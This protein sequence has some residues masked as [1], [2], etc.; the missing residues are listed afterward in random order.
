[1]HNHEVG[2][3]MSAKVHNDMVTVSEYEILNT[4]EAIEMEEEEGRSMVEMLGVLAIMGVLS[5][6]AIAG[7]KYAITKHRANTLIYESNKCAVVLAGQIL[8][9]TVPSMDECTLHNLGYGSFVNHIYGPNGTGDWTHESPQFSIEIENVNQKVCD[10]MLEMAGG[11]ISA[12]SPETCAATNTIML[13]YNN[14]LSET[15]PTGYVKEGEK[16]C[17]KDACYGFASNGCRDGCSSS[18]GV[19]SYSSIAQEGTSCGEDRLCD[20]N[21][22]CLCSPGYLLE[23]DECYID[24]CEGFEP[25][26]CQTECTSHHGVASYGSTAG[27]SCGEHGICSETGACIC[28]RGWAGASC[29]TCAPG[30]KGANCDTCASSFVE[31]NGECVCPEGVLI[32]ADNKCS[33]CVNNNPYLTPNDTKVVQT[34]IIK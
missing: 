26:A 22:N 32:G 28:T 3:E 29:D 4:N 27:V 25:S 20:G 15:C 16:W 13:T 34:P 2:G 19:A 31:I 7:F 33:V 14:D 12:F 30:Y 24:A 21:G 8:G 10:S 9:G 5:V 18:R 1:M 23:D 17:Y 11:V 6:S